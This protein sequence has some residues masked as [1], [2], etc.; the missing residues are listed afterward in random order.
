M[1]RNDNTFARKQSKT[2]HTLCCI[3]FCVFSFLYLYLY[4]ADVLTVAQHILSEGATAYD[5]LI[6]ACVITLALLLVH[7]FVYSVVSLYR[8]L[9]WLSYLPSF[10]L[11]AAL[12]DLQ[13]AHYASVYDTS[14]LWI[15]PL[16]LVLYGMGVRLMRELDSL[17]RDVS[18]GNIFSKSMWINLSGVTL[19]MLFVTAVTHTDVTMHHRIKIENCISTGDYDA[20]LRVGTGYEDT[21]ASLTML[22]I[23]SL[24]RKGQLPER[25]FQYPLSGGSRAFYPDGDRVKA[26]MVD[27]G[28]ITRFI[29]STRMGRRSVK[30]DY[31]LC[32]LLAD[33]QLNTFARELNKY[34]AADAQL[35]RY[36]KE[37][38]VLYSDLR[39]NDT[40][41]YAGADMNAAYRRF[42]DARKNL[43]TR[44]EIRSALKSE[45]S[46][47]Y[48]YYYTVRTTR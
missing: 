10:L 32:A 8:W 41:A 46:D 30:A 16:V 25:L 11:L 4:Q 5:P 27:N 14:W 18:P 1:T 35:P 29:R 47:T 26:L 9:Y 44:R 24:A 19:L 48:W 15:A 17:C 36:Y 45:Y 12:T 42:A 6:G 2:V 39:R 37:A 28:D 13:P 33:C 31:K 40:C 43:S 21:D 20:A 38:M 7:V 22:R 23:Y 34:Y 3:V